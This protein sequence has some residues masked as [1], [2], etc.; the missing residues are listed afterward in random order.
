MQARKKTIMIIMVITMAAGLLL[1]EIKA[2]GKLLI[3]TANGEKRY[4]VIITITQKEIMIKCSKKIFQPFNEFDAPKQSK[5]RLKT[6]GIYKIQ[7]TKKGNEIL[8]LDEGSLYKRYKHLFRPVWRIIQY[9]PYEE[10][11]KEALQFIMDNPADIKAIG[12]QLIKVIGKRCDVIND[13]DQNG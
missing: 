3:P 2:A 6:A 11:R 13:K 5:I 12:E 1:G 10:E 8:L 4:D 9:F 7:I